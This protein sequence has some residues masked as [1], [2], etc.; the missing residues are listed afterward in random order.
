MNMSTDQIWVNGLIE[1]LDVEKP[2]ATAIAIFEGRIIAVGND[3]DILN[4]KQSGT[5]I[6]NLDKKFVIIS[7]KIF[8]DPH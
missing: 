7:L 6:I 1:T 2:F 5:K 3:Q 4:L 8:L